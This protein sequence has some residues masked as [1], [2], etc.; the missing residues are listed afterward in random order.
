MS[1]RRT[2]A[3][4]HGFS[5]VETIL[6]VILVGVLGAFLVAL[7]GP[8]LGITPEVVGL[9]RNEALVERTLETIQ[10]DYL[11]QINGTT[12]DNA[13]AVIV[14]NEAAGNYDQDGVET[15]VA[16]ITFSTAG[17]EQAGGGVTDT[18]KV[19]VSLP[20]DQGNAHYR[21][22]TLLTHSR[23]SGQNNDVVNF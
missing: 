8:R 1:T 12:P 4:L 11:E 15:D 16:Y 19:T 14:Q 6:A 21:L 3:V 5:L 23:I 7:V 2:S 13:L 20:D 9:V 18:L 17:T 22:S 10:A